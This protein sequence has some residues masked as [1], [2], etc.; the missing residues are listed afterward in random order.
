MVIHHYRSNGGRCCCNLRRRHRPLSLRHYGRRHRRS[1]YRFYRRCFGSTLL[2]LCLSSVWRSDA[3]HPR[4][5]SRGFLTRPSEFRK[6]ATKYGP[7]PEPAACQA[8]KHDR[9]SE[10]AV[11]FSST[12]SHVCC[13]CLGAMLLFLYRF[14]IGETS[15]NRCSYTSRIVSVL[16]SMQAAP[17]AHALAARR[18]WDP[19]PNDNPTGTQHPGPARHHWVYIHT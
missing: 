7:T 12:P 15:S 10:A 13:S 14:P 18:Q 8:A 19:W 11:P 2:D 5:S 6:S 1:R 4:W 3:N 17:P 16:F 9:A